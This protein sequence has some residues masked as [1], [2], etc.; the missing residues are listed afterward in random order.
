[1]PRSFSR[2]RGFTLIELLVVIA[3]IAILAAILFPVFAKAREKARQTSCL[4]NQ[5]QIATG[6]LMYVQDNNELLPSVGN[7]WTSAF[8]TSNATKCLDVATLGNAFVY[9]AQLDGIPLQQVTAATTTTSGINHDVT[10]CF[11]TAD[12]ATTEATAANLIPA[13]SDFNASNTAYT[14]ADIA[15]SRHNGNY[16]ASFVDGHVALCGGTSASAINVITGFGTAALTIPPTATRMGT[17]NL[18]MQTQASGALA[19]ISFS[20]N[21]YPQIIPAGG[22]RFSNPS[23]SANDNWWNG[24]GTWVVG[25]SNTGNY[26]DVLGVAG[27]GGAPNGGYGASLYNC[28]A[29]DNIHFTVKATGGVSEKLD[30][31]YLD[32]GPFPLKLTVS[33]A[34]LGTQSVTYTDT[35]GPFPSSCYDWPVTFCTSANDVVTITLTETTADCYNL[36][37]GGAVLNQ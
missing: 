4:S 20:N 34:I 3:I 16:I 31:Y 23:V 8:P 36:Y 28:A 1:M 32:D 25:N 27:G 18:N 30:I 22:A 9:N 10:A 13:V 24:L 19:A 14:D 26:T 21:P 2:T 33:S 7:I 17:L 29:G 12:G 35:N 11:L 5:R 15:K 6:I 37:V